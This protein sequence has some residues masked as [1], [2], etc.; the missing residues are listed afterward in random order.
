MI[1]IQQRVQSKTKLICY[2]ARE[3][4]YFLSKEQYIWTCRYVGSGYAR[5]EKEVS[6]EELL[7]DRDFLRNKRKD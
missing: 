6:K 4:V 5:L 7:S 1:R 3:S 2:L